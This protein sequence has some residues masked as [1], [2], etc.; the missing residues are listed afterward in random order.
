M[1]FRQIISNVMQ[2]E[3][4][5]HLSDLACGIQ[6]IKFVHLNSRKTHFEMK[7]IGKS[8]MEMGRV[9]IFMIGRLF[10][11]GRAHGSTHQFFKCVVDGGILVLEVAIL[12]LKGL[13]KGTEGAKVG[14][15]RLMSSLCWVLST[16]KEMIS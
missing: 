13:N 16:I 6:A 8:G 4:M 15:M 1:K 10:I 3:V 9:G 5:F 12:V 2:G 11:E 7:M 14:S